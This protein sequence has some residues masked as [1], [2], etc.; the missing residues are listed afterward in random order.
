ML[1]PRIREYTT[2][3]IRDVFRLVG[4]VYTAV[5][6]FMAIGAQDDQIGDNLMAHAFVSSVV[7]L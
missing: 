2:Q 7:Y 6:L 1:S 5:M 3:H 4:A